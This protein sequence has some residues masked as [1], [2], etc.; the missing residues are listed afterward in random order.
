MEAKPQKKLREEKKVFGFDRGLAP[1]KII[2]ATDSSGI[3]NLPFV[4]GDKFGTLV[5]NLSNVIW[6]IVPVVGSKHNFQMFSRNYLN[7]GFF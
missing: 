1:E 7:R 5:I 2:G 4:Q 3:Y 6:K